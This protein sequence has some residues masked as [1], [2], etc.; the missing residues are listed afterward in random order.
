MPPQFARGREAV[1]DQGAGVWRLPAGGA[2]EGAAPAA[3][4]DEGLLPLYRPP[5]R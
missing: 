5:S 1:L 4:L 3:G 2:D